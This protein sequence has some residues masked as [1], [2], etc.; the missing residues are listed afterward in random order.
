MDATIGHPLERVVQSLVCRAV[1]L[2][3]YGGC[4]DLYNRRGTLER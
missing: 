1:R 4:S 3:I 2:S